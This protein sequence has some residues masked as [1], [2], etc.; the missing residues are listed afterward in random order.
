MARQSERMC[1]PAAR[2]ADGLEQGRASETRACLRPCEAESEE[3]GA[4]GSERNPPRLRGRRERQMARSSYRRRQSADK[5]QPIGDPIEVDEATDLIGSFTVN[6]D[7]SVVALVTTVKFP[8]GDRP[9]RI[10][11]KPESVPAFL[12]AMESKA[13][14]VNAFLAQRGEADTAAVAKADPV[15]AERLAAMEAQGGPAAAEARAFR[16]HL[17]TLASEP[18]DSEA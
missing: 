9:V 18:E 10:G 1:A 12:A 5:W 6:A 8:D 16:A 11:V 2:S 15:L 4:K 14:E 7:G 3:L 17:A 13:A